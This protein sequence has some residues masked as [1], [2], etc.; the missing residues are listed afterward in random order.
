[1][2]VCLVGGG[3]LCFVY[4]CNTATLT[5]LQR[6]IRVRSTLL[7]VKNQ[8]QKLGYEEGAG[9]RGGHGLGC[10]MPG[11]AATLHQLL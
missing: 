11:E 9:G 6:S 10:G 7:G 2:L 4:H 1:M 5:L 3:Q 8:G